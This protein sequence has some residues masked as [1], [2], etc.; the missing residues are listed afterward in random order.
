[1]LICTSEDARSKD[2]VKSEMAELDAAG[3]LYV[4]LFRALTELLEQ[5]GVATDPIRAECGR[6][7]L[8]PA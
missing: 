2:R 1:M 6:D 8:R 5:T 4:A 3:T 7:R